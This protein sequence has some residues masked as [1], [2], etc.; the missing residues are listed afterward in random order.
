MWIVAIVQLEWDMAGAC[1][2][3]IVVCNL[4]YWEEPSLIVL[5]EIDK[6]LEVCFHYTILLFCLV[7][8]LRVKDVGEPPLDAKKV[9]K[10]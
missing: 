7:I 4:S 5:L 10:R 8:R 6:N 9:A 3:G 1:I 2:F